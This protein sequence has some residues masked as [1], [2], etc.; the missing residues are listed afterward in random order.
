MLNNIIVLICLLFCCT[1]IAQNDSLIVKYDDSDLEPFTISN[2]D[3]NEYA[4]DE[5]F[6]YEIERKENTWWDAVK[7]WLYNLFSRFFEWLF[8]I[9]NAPSYLAFFLR[10]VPYLL[11]GLLLYLIIR[12]FINANTRALIQANKN[13]NLVVLS[14]DER[15]I[16]SENIE[17]LI[18]EAVAA[19]NYRLAI[20][21]YYLFILKL[22]S[23]EQL[24][25]WQLQKTNDDYLNELK[26][27]ALKASFEK[28]TLLYDYIWYGEF[29]I[30]ED[31]YSKAAALFSNLRNNVVGNG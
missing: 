12:F 23:D 10:M 17:Q 26:S 30:K 6:D 22:M 5:K 2:E 15:I 14:E 21:Y 1:S 4:D 29:N 3:L 31:E 13:N 20:R 19:K 7:N 16:Q 11:L 18:K 28:V 9:E 24:I 27:N 25:N 8:G